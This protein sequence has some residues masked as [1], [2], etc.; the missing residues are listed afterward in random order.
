MY[1]FLDTE[2]ADV[3]GSELV[4]LAL[5]SQDGFHHFYAERDPLPDSPTDFVK[6]VVY[7]LLERG[8]MAMSDQA[9]TTGLR[10]FL[11]SAPD[12]IVIADFHHDLALVRYV[13]AGFEMPEEQAYACGP[14]PQ[15]VMTRLLK[16]GLMGMLVGDYFAGHPEAAAR[17]HH[18]MVDAEALRQAW[19]ATTG[20]IGTPA[21]AR[22]LILHNNPPPK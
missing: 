2:W 1:F 13:L 19:L 12:P 22:T 14:M 17:R 15:P 18:A 11:N 20:G 6:H 16:E 8:R 9:M 21:W 4:S 10:A 5:V 3:T 7:P